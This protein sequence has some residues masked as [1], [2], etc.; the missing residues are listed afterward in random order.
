MNA[1]GHGEVES[2]PT[3]SLLN[4][5]TQ[6]LITLVTEAQ[7]IEALIIEALVPVMPGTTVMPWDNCGG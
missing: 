1:I 2:K 3:L 7:I 5:S 4:V 6:I